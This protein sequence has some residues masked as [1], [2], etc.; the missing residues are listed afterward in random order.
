MSKIKEMESKPQVFIPYNLLPEAKDWKNGRVY[1]VRA[2][3]RQTGS[4][5]QGS[6]FE[7]E[8]AVS[9]DGEKAATY[10]TSD[11]GKLMK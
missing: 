6:T 9:L 5:E 10:L 1:R 3:L 11:D 8:D 7:L 4:S 2:V